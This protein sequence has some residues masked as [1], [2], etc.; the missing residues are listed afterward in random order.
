MLLFFCQTQC[1]DWC[2]IR[3]IG[4][5]HSCKSI[6]GLLNKKHTL[7]I[8]YFPL[9]FKDVLKDVTYSQ[10]MSYACE[11]KARIMC[12]ITE[13]PAG[14]NGTWMIIN[15]NNGKSSD[16]FNVIWGYKAHWKVGL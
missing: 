15:R 8:L 6:F 5:N 16:V 10:N 1:R 4:L 13:I 3:K 7:T 2:K 14:S 12:H 11:N 9:F